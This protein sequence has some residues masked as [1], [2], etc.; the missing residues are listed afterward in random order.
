MGEHATIGR[1]YG[2][3]ATLRIF[4]SNATGSTATTTSSFWVSS[5]GTL[6]TLKARQGYAR[7]AADSEFMQAMGPFFVGRAVYQSP[8]SE[9]A[10][11]GSGY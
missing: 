3:P 11:E 1:G 2:K 7:D 6:S 9:K 4:G 10:R 5:A 8:L